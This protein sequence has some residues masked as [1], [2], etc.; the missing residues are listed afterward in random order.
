MTLCISED[1]ASSVGRPKKSTTQRDLVAARPEC[2]TA[3]TGR[4]A[5]AR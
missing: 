1:R 5:E 3:A 2:L 4:S